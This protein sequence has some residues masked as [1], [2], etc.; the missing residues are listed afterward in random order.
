MSESERL[1]RQELEGVRGDLSCMKL[2]AEEWRETS[3][4]YRALAMFWKQRYEEMGH[5]DKL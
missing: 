2:I 1:L 4:E 3:D 5:E